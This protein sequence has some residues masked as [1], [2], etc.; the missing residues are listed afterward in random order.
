MTADAAG[1]PTAEIIVDVDLVRRL[2]TRQHPQ[3]AHLSIT[4]MESGWDNVILRLGDDLALRLPR[5][6]AA[7]PLILKEQKWLLMLAQ[8]LP[9]PIP[10]PL[11]LGV[12]DESYPFHWSV[13][14][15]Q[16]GEAADLA[17]PHEDQAAVAAEFL[18]ALHKI[19]L[20]DN[21]PTNPV[22]D[23][24]LSGKQTDVE[25]RMKVLLKNPQTAALLTP[26]IHSLWQS[27]LKSPPALKSCWV[28]GDI[29]ARNVLTC[30]GKISAF[31]DWGDMCAGDP[32]SDLACI[33]A[34]FE[35]AAARKEFI[36]V[37]GMD[38][39]LVTRAMGWAIFF[40]VLLT[41][42]GMKD[43]PRHYKMGMATLRRVDA[44]LRGGILP[45]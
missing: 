1:T 39:G 19:P 8:H 13:L 32:A 4:I 31:I 44:D 5:R 15:W 23:C 35:N 17:P 12:P 25:K 30:N 33:W 18:T 26:Q 16:D 11:H 6:A 14:K 3:L 9:L 43:T 42:T 10:V 37:Y 27:A 40:G 29:H 38:D 21:A 34:L 41:E 20:P 24:P 36:A 2:L 22:R 28:A 45:A 7:E